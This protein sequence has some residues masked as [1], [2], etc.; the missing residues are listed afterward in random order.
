MELRWPSM[1]LLDD[2]RDALT[3]GFYSNSL[4]P[5]SGLEELADQARAKAELARKVAE[6]RR[7]LREQILAERS[8]PAAK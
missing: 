1:D 5:D 7:E 8:S 2:Y 6:R 3:R 4:R